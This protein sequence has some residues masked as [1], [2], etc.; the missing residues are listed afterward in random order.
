MIGK[1]KRLIQDDRVFYGICDAAIFM[2]FCKSLV[3]II[4]WVVS[5]IR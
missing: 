4:T 1:I 3:N 5:V 2:A